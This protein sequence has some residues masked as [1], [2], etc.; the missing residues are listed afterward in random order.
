MRWTETFAVTVSQSN[1]FLFLI[2]LHLL[3]SMCSFWEHSQQICCMLISVSESAS[4]GPPTHVRCLFYPLSQFRTPLYITFEHI[5]LGLLPFR[6][7][8]LCKQGASA[9]LMYHQHLAKCLSNEKCVSMTPPN[10]FALGCWILIQ[11][12]KVCKWIGCLIGVSMNG[13]II[14]V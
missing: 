1:S 4:Q 14:C 8:A 9:C 5:Y 6:L 3:P 13:S 7:Y 11:R 12:R 2:L 10:G